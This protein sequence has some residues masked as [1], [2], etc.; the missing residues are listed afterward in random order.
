MTDGPVPEPVAPRPGLLRTIGILN[1]AFGGLLFLCGA[2]YAAVFVPFLLRNDPIQLDPAETQLVVDDMR[3]QIVTEL[4]QKRA[5]ASSAAEKE[6]LRAVLTEIQAKQGKLADQVDFDAV[7]ARLPWIS[8]Y[9]WADVASGPILSLPM[10]I[11]GFGLVRLKSW[12]RKLALG[13]AGLQL[14]RVVALSALAGFVV[15]PQL[16]PPARAFARSDFGEAFARAAVERSIIGGGSASQARIDP[17][18]FVRVLKA[19]GN[20][21]TLLSLGL[22]A[23]YPAIVLVVLTRPGGRAA[24]SASDGKPLRPDASAVHVGEAHPV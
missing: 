19:L 4:H 12:A 16:A 14:A 21:S 6:R 15:I 20:G 10:L 24:C 18:E 11:A 7:N 8:R 9:L 3:R 22:R 17:E 1:L 13:V 23:I 2:G 5:A